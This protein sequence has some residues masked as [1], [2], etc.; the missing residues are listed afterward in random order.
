MSGDV[1]HVVLEVP[2]P[3]GGA[4]R[5]SRRTYNGS[6]P[7]TQL[8]RL[9]RDEQS[10]ALRHTKNNTTIRDA[11]L[12]AVID[13]L[14]RIARKTGSTPARVATSGRQ[15]ALPGVRTPQPAASVPQATDA[16]LDLIDRTF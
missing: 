8:A 7:F 13:A 14:T 3:D 16:D 9:Y 2:R 12:P 6:A 4:L 10:G 15:P 11:D 1:E 5:I